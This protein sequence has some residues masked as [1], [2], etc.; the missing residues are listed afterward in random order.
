MHKFG[1]I[2]TEH[3]EITEREFFQ[4]E[5][6]VS[7]CS[8]ANY[9]TVK[10]ADNLVIASTNPQFWLEFLAT[11]PKSSVV[12]ILLGNETYDPATFNAFNGVESL[13]HVFVYNKPTK[14]MPFT[15]IKT[16]V[17]H[18][19]DLGFKRFPYP[20]SIYRDFRNSMY[21]YKKF[22]SIKIN[23]PHSYLPQGYSNNFAYKLSTAF[24]LDSSYS[25]LSKDLMNRQKSVA[26]RSNFLSFSGQPT[27]RRRALVIHA[28]KK[29]M[30]MPPDYT[31]G[32]R[33]A[34]H[35]GDSTYIN[36]LCDSK[37]ILV[38]PGSFN[39]S[40][41]RYTESLICGAIPVILAK[42]SLDPSENT[43][44]TNELPGLIP[45]SAKLLLRHLSKISDQEFQAL[46]VGIRQFDFANIED[47]RNKFREITQLS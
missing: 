30:G 42:N 34:S 33:G 5:L 27:N 39:N 29:Y 28:A 22:S 31:E 8:N 43:N 38:P 1:Y 10:D 18:I 24:N 17:G 4:R 16:L 36:Q 13:R 19:V 20:D 7:I 23:Y 32:F 35:A 21:L 15:L 9:K 46:I 26:S 6:K 47:F 37:F 25:L 41:H 45:F 3:D 40:N 14:I 12:F 11:R 44:W 2:Y